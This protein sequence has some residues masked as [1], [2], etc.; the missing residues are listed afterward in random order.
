VVSTHPTAG[1]A[2][3]W[4][5]RHGKPR[6]DPSE[7]ACWWPL[8][9]DGL[10]AV[11]ALRE[12]LPDQAAWFSS[13]EPKALTTARL[14]T[15]PLTPVRVVPALVEHQRAATDWEDD[16]NA[17][18]ARVQRV[19]EA[20]D[21]PASPGW[22]PLAATRARIVPAV[23][24]ILSTHRGR[25]VVLVGHGTAWTLL[26]S[27]LTASPPDLDAWAALKMPDVWRLDAPAV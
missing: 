17:W 4:L 1:E 14:L 12:R 23:E 5:V 25:D 11:L 21:E 26:R 20:P 8:D 3:V 27:V 18:R 15:G 22:E 6:V 16:P 13:P 24:R 10:D 9:G 7:A 2:A 19:F